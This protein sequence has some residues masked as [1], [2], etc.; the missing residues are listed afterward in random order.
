MYADDAIIYT[1]SQSITEIERALTDEME[2]ISKWFDNNRLVIDLKK[3]KTE[4]MLFGTAKRR[5]VME[6]LIIFLGVKRRNV[7]I[8]A[9]GKYLDQSL[10]MGLH[11]DK[12]YK[13]VSS[14][15]S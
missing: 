1:S 4:T 12:V 3:G 6:G 10:N 13:K 2:N 8:H 14:N 5:S 7:Q 15:I 11:L 9:P